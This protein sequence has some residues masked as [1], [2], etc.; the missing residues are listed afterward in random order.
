MASLIT[1]SEEERDEDEEVG[2]G[3][4]GRGG[5]EEDLVSVHAFKKLVSKLYRVCVCV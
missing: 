5:R 1:R 2:G 4:G 3:R